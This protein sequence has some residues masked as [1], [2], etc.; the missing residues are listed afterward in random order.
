MKSDREILLRFG[1]PYQGIICSCS[2]ER[3]YMTN[4][5]YHVVL[6][7]GRVYPMR[8]VEDM[9]RFIDS[10]MYGTLRSYEDYLTDKIFSSDM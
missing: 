7:N 3:R 2:L 4:G 8:L 1:V 6:F 9:F 10:Y 5:I